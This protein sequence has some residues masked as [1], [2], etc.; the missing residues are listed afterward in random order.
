MDD[1]YEVR[2]AQFLM[3]QLVDEGVANPGVGVNGFSYGGGLSMTLAVLKDRVMMPDG[4]LVPWRSPGG[5]PMRIAAAAPEAGWSDLAYALMPNGR[6]LDYAADAPY[7]GPRGD[8]PVG[9]MKET[10]VSALYGTGAYAS[11]Y[12]PPGTD[13][14]INAWYALISAGEPYGSTLGPIADEVTRYHSGYYIDHSQPPAPLLLTAGWNDD[15]MPPD[16]WIRIYNRTR[17]QFPGDPI[18]LL[19]LD[20]GHQ[21]S[22]MK[23]ADAAVVQARVDAWFDHY[24]K[25]IGPAP[26]SSVETLTTT[27]PKSAPSDGPR[28]AD[29]WYHAAPGEIRLESAAAQTIAPGADN[30]QAAPAFDPVAADFDPCKTIG[31]DDVPGTATYR[32]RPAPSGGFT[33]LGSPTIIA[34]L[35]GGGPNSQVAARLVDVNPA[36]GTESLVARALYRPGSGVQVFQLH[37]N[38][39]KFD[40]GHVAKL[41]LLAADSPYGRVSNGQ[42][43]VTVSDLELRL[44]VAEKPGSLGGLVQAVAPKVLPPGYRLAADYLGRGGPGSVSTTS[45]RCASSRGGIAGRRLH[46]ARLGWKRSTIRRAY[47]SRRT[48]GSFDYFCLADGGAV[49]AGYSSRT[50]RRHLSGRERRRTQGR[51][52]LLLTTSTHLRLRGLRVGSSTRTL[53]RRLP[54]ARRYR[55]GRNTWY[56]ARSRSSTLA[57]K[58]RR[59]RIRSLGIADRRLTRTRRP[60]QRFLSGFF[61]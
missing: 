30:P 44:P 61:R 1:R 53:R 10:F 4:S 37:P 33:L 11:N 23:D 49:S 22:Q 15:I 21:R 34:K 17:T 39:Y 55:A 48:R 6:T 26:S 12:A 31:S 56:L 54:R 36:K 51:A 60:Q 59:G 50:L 20:Y 27:C 41:E 5:I 35:A 25:G 29:S 9:V 40:T 19:F 24:L 42:A 57:F 38:S 58:T 14:D 28:R 18:S 8:A 13:P 32:L 7:R 43:T 47:P 3:S 52:V 45:P 46:R 2:D 16:E